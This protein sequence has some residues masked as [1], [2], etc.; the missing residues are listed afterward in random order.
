MPL[1]PPEA[2]ERSP[3][4]AA[5][6][7]SAVKS[8]YVGTAV[9]VGA[10]FVAQIFIMRSLGP[11]IVGTF[12]YALLLYGVLALVI[13]QGF[14]W[15]LIQFTFDDEEEIATVFS[16]IM[17]V[18]VLSGI[19]VYWVSFPV[20][21]ALDNPLAGMV[22]RYSAPSYILIGLFVVAQA[23]LR[24][25]LRFA[26]IQ[27]ATTG[28][29]LLAYPVVGVAMA[30]AGFG[31]W[32]LLAAWYVQ[33][34]MQ[35]LIV[36]RYSRHSLRLSNPFRATK[37]GPLGRHVAGINLL[38]WSVSNAS[39]VIVG[40]MG[41]VALG[42]FNAASMLARTPTMHLVQTLPPIIFSATSAIR[43]DVV[44][45]R[46]MY[47]GALTAIGFVIIPAYAF[48]ATHSDAI[49]ALLFGDKWLRAASVFSSLSLGM[50]PL[51]IS[52]LSGPMLTAIGAQ[53]AVFYSQALALLVTLVGLYVAI[54]LPTYEELYWVG[55][56]MTTAYAAAMSMQLVVLIRRRVFSTS[57][58][59]GAVKGPSIVA[60]LMAVP[61]SVVWG[62][63]QF[64]LPFQAAAFFVKC[65]VAAVLVWSFPRFFLGDLLM[66]ALSKVAI[67]RRI[68]SS[69]S[70]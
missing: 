67:G 2:V 13:D 31:V 20:E 34:L 19:V 4:I 51:A 68:P 65:V 56:S 49:I 26:E 64:Y 50:V 16:R 24:A 42:H 54:H 1:E 63:G 15:S 5:R 36:V 33:G 66:D 40:G 6:S 70:R 35:I 59:F 7:L 21:Q 38:H 8:N 11:E 25:E 23:R 22:F 37:S 44:M 41:D 69:A 39:S 14:G 53:S 43:E 48:A 29:Y 12:A 9:R 30:L 55:M 58:F 62:G 3:G 32:S 18:S 28:A 17:L 61:E 46:K 10:Q 27:S 52:S 45:I 47:L 57:E 60:L